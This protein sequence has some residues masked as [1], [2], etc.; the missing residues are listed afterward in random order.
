[1]TDAMQ[2]EG[3]PRLPAGVREGAR[4]GPAER[5]HGRES[6]ARLRSEGRRAGDEVL[7]LTVARNGLAWARIGCAVPRQFGCA[8]RRNKMRRLIREAFRLEKAALPPGYDLLAG[9]G[10]G[11]GE[12]DLERVRRSLVALAND[13]VRRLERARGKA[14][15]S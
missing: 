14:G 15:E 1:M 11:P 9:P 13:C 3:R 12:P 5:L 6:F 7:R 4:L 2:G 10:S 8:V